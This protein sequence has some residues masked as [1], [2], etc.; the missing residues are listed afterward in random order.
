MKKITFASGEVYE[1]EGEVSVYE[2]ASAVGII[3]RE[4]LTA[5]VNGELCELSTKVSEDAEVFRLSGK[6][7]CLEMIAV[8]TTEEFLSP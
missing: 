5:R 2:A 8:T 4:V 7:E 6:Y 3:S 1:F